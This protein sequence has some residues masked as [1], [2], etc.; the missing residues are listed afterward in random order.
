MRYYT[1]GCDGYFN[2][3]VLLNDE[4]IGE[5]VKQSNSADIFCSVQSY[6]SDGVEESSQLV[7]DIDMDSHDRAYELARDIAADVTNHY[8]AKTALWFSGSKGFH[9]VTNLGAK[10]SASNVA[11]KDI[12]FRF[13]DLI[14]PSMYKIRSMFRLANSVNGKSGLRKIQVHNESM[15]SILKRAQSPQPFTSMEIDFDNEEFLD[16]HVD[17][18]ANYRERIANTVLEDV[19]G[20]KQW[21]NELPPCMAK[22]LRE[23]VPDGSRWNFCFYLVKLWRECGLEMEQSI[24]ESKCHSIFNDA[25]YTAGMIVH[26]Y[27][28]SRLAI[29]CK[30]G[31][32]SGLMQSNCDAACRYSEDYGDELTRNFIKSL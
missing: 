19:D 27:M 18:V 6:D 4:T 14:D 20:S 15:S 24:Q 1:N 22:L 23:G 29:G 16:D 28:N 5:I 9:V 11:M 31:A 30:S 2:R 12:A 3:H 10:G 25:G 13:S 8:S 26:Y 21:R 17:A 7:F 32:L